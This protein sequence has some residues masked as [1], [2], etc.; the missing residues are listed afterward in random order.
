[1]DITSQEIGVLK[2]LVK[3]FGKEEI[4]KEITTHYEGKRI[5]VLKNYEVAICEDRLADAVKHY[6]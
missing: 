3:N 4:L 6:K 1:M 2:L 5:E